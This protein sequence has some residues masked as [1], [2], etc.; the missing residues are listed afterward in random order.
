[1]AI[2]TSKPAFIERHGLWDEARQEAAAR[3]LGELDALDLEQ[4]RIGWGDQHGI[5]RGKTLT[6]A[7]FRRVLLEG[8]DFQTATL[9]FDTSNHP[10]VPP[11]GRPA[12]AS[13]S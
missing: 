4:V 12:S 8:K 3:L 7:E 1:M 9:I 2:T 10:A 11:F 6:V 5:V 13:R